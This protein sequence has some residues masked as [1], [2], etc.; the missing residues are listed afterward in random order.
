MTILIKGLWL[1]LDLY[2]DVET[3]LA[4]DT[5][6]LKDMIEMASIQNMI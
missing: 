4:T 5:N 6:R 1:A 3:E 2:Q